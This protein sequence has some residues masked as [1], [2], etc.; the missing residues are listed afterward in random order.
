M[1]V[2]A[3]HEARG[4]YLS[5]SRHSESF[6]PWCGPLTHLE[7]Q[8]TSHRNTGQNLVFVPSVEFAMS[9]ENPWGDRFIN[10]RILEVF[11]VQGDPQSG[12]SDNVPL[13]RLEQNPTLL[14]VSVTAVC[15]LRIPPAREALQRASKQLANKYP[16]LT[17]RRAL[18]KNGTRHSDNYLHIPQCARR[19]RFNSSGTNVVI[20]CNNRGFP[21]SFVLWPEGEV[22]A[23]PEALTFKGWKAGKFP[24]PLPPPIFVDSIEVCTSNPRPA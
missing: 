5:F 16:V 11:N 1:G 22:D 13:T 12:R 17:G 19:C 18:C 23:F 6:D 10:A 2:A 20:E 7:N 8:A 15:V 14:F 21:L 4:I 9:I 24:T 3:G